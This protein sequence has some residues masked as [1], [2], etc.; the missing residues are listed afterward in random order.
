MKKRQN[1]CAQTG[2]WSVT[3]VSQAVWV[4]QTSGSNRPHLRGHS[5]YPASFP[6]NTPQEL[7]ISN[8]GPQNQQQNPIKVQSKASCEISRKSPIRPALGS[9]CGVWRVPPLAMSC[10]SRELQC[11]IPATPAGEDR[12]PSLSDGNQ[13]NPAQ[14]PRHHTGSVLLP[15]ASRE[16]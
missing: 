16:S 7:R 4:Y 1:F 11:Q 14:P 10:G 2:P 9:F 8:G 5:L 6:P 13:T 12:N 15:R 3:G